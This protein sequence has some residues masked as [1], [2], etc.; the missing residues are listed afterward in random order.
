ML[1]NLE[2]CEQF[3]ILWSDGFIEGL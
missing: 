3:E 1:E 2:L